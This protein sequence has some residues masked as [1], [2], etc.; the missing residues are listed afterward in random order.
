MHHI[1]IGSSSLQTRARPDFW[2][3]SNERV[4]MNWKDGPHKQGNGESSHWVLTELESLDDSKQDTD[5]VDPTEGIKHLHG[6]LE[7]DKEVD[8]LGL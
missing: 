8:S 4:D 1:K 3:E 5:G 7:I 2:R 6:R